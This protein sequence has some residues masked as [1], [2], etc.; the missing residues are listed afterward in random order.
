MK[1]VIVLMA[2]FV[3][4]QQGFAQV[5][6]V[7]TSKAK[8]GSSGRVFV[9]SVI[10]GT[11]A[12]TL[13]GAASLAFTSNPAGNLNAVARGASYGLY[14]GILLGVYLTYGVPDEDEREENPD[15]KKERPPGAF[16]GDGLPPAE[17]GAPPPTSF[18]P[19]QKVIVGL[20]TFPQ[21]GLGLGLGVSF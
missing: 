9:N 11:L 14:S 17:E 6:P 10:Y 12:G 19:Q 15:G 1:K 3:S 20:Q 5:P 8:A 16:P 13:I 4:S 21:G 18:A 7:G 2:L